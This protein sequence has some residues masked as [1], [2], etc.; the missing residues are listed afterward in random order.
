MD[1][2]SN[3][4]HLRLSQLRFAVSFLGER[5]NAAW[6]DTGFLGRTGLRYAEFNF[7][8]STVAAAGVS[9]SEAARRIHDDRIGRGGVFHLFRLPPAI[10]ESVHFAMLHGDPEPIKCMIADRQTALE[11]LKQMGGAG[12]VKGVE[13]P[14]QV[15]AVADILTKEAVSALA[16]HYLNGFLNEKRVFPY[17]LE[18]DA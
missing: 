12:G 16:G 5:D 2:R 15:G 13:G 4:G 9:A 11:A 8:R 17:F 18:G 6:W 14:V 1:N 7:P 3:Q 10:E